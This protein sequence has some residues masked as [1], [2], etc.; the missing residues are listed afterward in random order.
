MFKRS[1]PLVIS[2]R[3]F[4]GW[5]PLL[6]QVKEE[7]IE[8]WRRSGNTNILSQAILTDAHWFQ[9]LFL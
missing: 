1:A 5:S 9:K 6:E 3:R 8:L 7:G 2:K 4:R